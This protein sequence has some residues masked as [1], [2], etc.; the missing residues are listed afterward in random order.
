MQSA[1]PGAGPLCVCRR[2]AN[3]QSIDYGV[4]VY[5][6]IDSVLRPARRARLN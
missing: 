5:C 2:G 6:T 3:E 1:P 4:C